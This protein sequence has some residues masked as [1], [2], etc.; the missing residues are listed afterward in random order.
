MADQVLPLG[1]VVV[2]TLPSASNP[3]FHAPASPVAT[4]IGLP[5]TSRP[6]AVETPVASVM[7]VTNPLAYTNSS[8]PSLVVV[9]ADGSG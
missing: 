8:R 1:A 5:S 9:T 7:L 2:V 6:V 3:Y 4:E